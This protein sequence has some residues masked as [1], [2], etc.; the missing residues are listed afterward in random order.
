MTYNE[1]K[2]IIDDF[3]QQELNKFYES[4]RNYDTS[5]FEEVYIKV[6]DNLNGGFEIVEYELPQDDMTLEEIVDYLWE[7]QEDNGGSWQFEAELNEDNYI[8]FEISEISFDYD[9]Q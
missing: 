7:L 6:Y 2:S 8:W 3:K 4:F 1:L 9:W 5:K